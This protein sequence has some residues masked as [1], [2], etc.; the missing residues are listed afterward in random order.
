MILNVM[1][2]MHAVIVGETSAKHGGMLSAESVSETDDSDCEL[3]KKSC[4][5]LEVGMECN[6][7][8]CSQQLNHNLV[9]RLPP[10]AS[11]KCMHGCMH[12]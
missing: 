1:E 3:A 12:E 8:S 7:V 6:K 9:Q 5:A 11:L 4:S 10:Q 2:T